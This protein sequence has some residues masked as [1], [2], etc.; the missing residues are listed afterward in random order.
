MFELEEML[1]QVK[2]LEKKLKELGESL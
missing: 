2:E 1:Q